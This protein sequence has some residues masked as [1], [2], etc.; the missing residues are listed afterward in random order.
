MKKLILI[1]VLALGFSEMEAQQIPLYSNYFFTPYV[2]NP[3]LSGRDGSLEA[4]L[5]HRRQWTGIQ[6]SPETTALTLN[7]ARNESNVGWSMYAF[8]DQANILGRLGAYGNY[9]YRVRFSD[10]ASLMLGLGAGFIN[11]SIDQSAIRAQDAG[12]IF[13]VVPPNRTNFDINAGLAL[14]IAD[15]TLGAAAP[16]LLSQNLVYSDN[17]D[18]IN[19]N[20]IRHYVFSAQYDFKFGGD[21][22]ILTPLV[23]VRAAEQN[24][25][26][27]VDAGLLFNLT[28]YGYVGA[29][30][31]SDYAVTANAGVNLNEWLTVGY[32]YDFSLN[33]YSSQLGTSHEFMLTFRFGN[34]S[35]NERM[36]NEIK[37]MKLMQRRQRDE[38]EEAIDEALE[39]FKDQ[40]KNEIQQAI[41]EEKKKMEA[42]FE[43]MRQQGGNNNAGGTNAGGG[44]AN[45]STNSS[46]RT[47]QG[48]NANNNA[49][50]Q[51]SGKNGYQ[52][53]NNAGTANNSG[54]SSA[55]QSSNVQPG[56]KGYYVTAG[57]FGQSSNAEAL[58]NRLN[59]QGFDAGIFRDPSNNFFYVFLL[60]FNSYQE[61]DQA[62]A[63]KLNGRY[64]G[65]LWIKIMD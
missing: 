39:E 3:A 49:G 28:E 52:P 24:V 35:E 15:F 65:N 34:D 40:Y 10:N 60:K 31:R 6:G 59:A 62:K 8:S 19:Y 45:N 42:D 14:K 23:M 53:A 56:S 16:Q 11:Q 20:L 64:T 63:S 21:K 29:M 12:D 7:G 9:S 47:Q 4:N 25:P 32:A 30:Y 36:Q 2:Y 54:Y 1:I 57:V 38:T 61:A 33:E 17:V 44:S 18:Q 27:Q 58:K 5:L 41:E 55:N 50:S 48:G 26:V 37:R 46:G 51:S 13:T 22:Q 43:R